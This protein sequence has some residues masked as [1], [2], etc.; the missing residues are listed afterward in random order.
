MSG[1]P[2]PKKPMHRIAYTKLTQEQIAAKLGP[3]ADHGPKSISPLAADF[4]GQSF[5]IRHLLAITPAVYFFAVEALTRIKGWLAPL[6]FVILMGVGVFYAYHGVQD[7]WA[8]I[9]ERERIEPTLKVA[10]RFVIYPYSR[11]RHKFE[12]ERAN[13]PKGQR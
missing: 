12:L 4:A 10:Q 2:Y 6:L 11:T 3:V 5:G 7:P 1:T 13:P 8:R 9:E